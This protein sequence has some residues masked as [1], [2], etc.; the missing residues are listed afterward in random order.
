MRVGHYEVATLR[1]AAHQARGFQDFDEGVALALEIVF[2]VCEVVLRARLLEA[3]S[4]RLLQ[5][6]YPAECGPLPD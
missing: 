2:H 4:H 5:R 1:N 3:N 6:G